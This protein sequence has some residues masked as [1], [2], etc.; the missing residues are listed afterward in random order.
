M[1]F[2][3]HDLDGYLLAPKGTTDLQAPDIDSK[4]SSA[5]STALICPGPS[6]STAGGGAARWP[7]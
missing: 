2:R 3:V 1:S 7:A 6:N 5:N 4:S